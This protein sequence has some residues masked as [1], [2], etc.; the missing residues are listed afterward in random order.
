MTEPVTAL[1]EALFNQLQKET[2]VLLHTTD[3]EHGSPTSSAISWIYAATPTTLRFAVDGRS[4]LVANMS[5]NPDVCVTVFSSGTVQAV[6][7]PAKVISDSLEGV[8]F[9]LVCLE[10]EITNIRDAMF[11]GARLSVTPEYE[12]TYDKRAAEKLDGQ[13]FEAMKKA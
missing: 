11:Y 7:G 3:A 12:K 10:I 2:F 1:S 6:Y 5:A 9:K 8:P 4:R 13:V